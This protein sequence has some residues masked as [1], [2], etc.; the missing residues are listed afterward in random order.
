MY[1]FTQ[2]LEYVKCSIYMYMCR[3]SPCACVCSSVIPLGWA[4]LGFAQALSTVYN[5]KGRFQIGDMEDAT[6]TIE[7]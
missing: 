3:F 7:A 2:V 5:E 4:R 6:E 1:I